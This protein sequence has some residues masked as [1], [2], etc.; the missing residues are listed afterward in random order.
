MENDIGKLRSIA[1]VS[2]I[3]GVNVVCKNNFTSLIKL[4]EWSFDA[5]NLLQNSAN[6]KMD[7]EDIYTPLDDLLNLPVSK[8]L[9]IL[10]KCSN[11]IFNIKC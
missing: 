10:D 6:T 1:Y 7:L 3:N 8:K 2:K 9:F 5:Q 4:P 11:K